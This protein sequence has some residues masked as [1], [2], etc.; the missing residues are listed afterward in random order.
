MDMIIES[1]Q[2]PSHEISRKQPQL[3]QKHILWCPTVHP[4][5]GDGNGLVLCHL[6]MENIL[7]DEIDIICLER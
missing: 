4:N 3:S 5:H 1:I 2:L 7:C 6:R